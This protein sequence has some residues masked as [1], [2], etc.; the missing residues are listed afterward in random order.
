MLPSLGVMQD[1]EFAFAER[2]SSG[3]IFVTEE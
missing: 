1:L 2:L 3:S